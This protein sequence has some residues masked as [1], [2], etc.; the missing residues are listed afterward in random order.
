MEMLKQHFWTVLWLFVL[1]LGPVIGFLVRKRLCFQARMQSVIVCILA[2]SVACGICATL[3]RFSFTSGSLAAANLVLAYLSANCLLFSAFRRQPG[4]G[5]IVASRIFALLLAFFLT[6]SL[7]YAL[8][9]NSG[10]DEDAKAKTETP[11]GDH[12]FLIRTSGGMLAQNWEG[13]EITQRSPVLP[14]IQKTLY[15]IHIGETEDCNEGTVAA[16][17]DPVLREVVV[18]CDGPK[19]YIWAHVKMP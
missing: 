9:F 13:V 1:P 15:S 3:T 14:L 11:L 19:P 6:Y 12:L 18:E 4:S 5:L 10:W 2:A 16:H 17:P 8:L 7:G